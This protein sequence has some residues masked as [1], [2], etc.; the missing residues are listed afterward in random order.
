M[1]GFFG[2]ELGLF[3]RI[4]HVVIA[5]FVIDAVNVEVGEIVLGCLLKEMIEGVLLAGNRLLVFFELPFLFG[6]DCFF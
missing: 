3:L 4:D 6:G 1:F 2:F 5:D